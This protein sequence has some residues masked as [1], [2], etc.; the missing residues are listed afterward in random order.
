VTAIASVDKQPGAGDALVLVDVQNDFL[1]GGALGIAAGGAILGPLN[2]YVLEFARGGL[3]V[4]A[5]RDWHPPKHCSFREQGGPWPVHCVAGTWGAELSSRLVLPASVR[6]VSKGQNPMRDAYSGFQGTDLAVQLRDLHC[7]RLFVGGL[8]TDY[9]VR[10]SVKDALAAGFEVV[11]LA[12]AVAA[13]NIHPGDG[14]GALEEMEVSGAE[15][16]SM[17]R[18]VA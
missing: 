2:R 14:A 7:K 11:V 12:D 6:I 9:C 10:A 17:A 1:P 4:F 3:P 18:I 16:V 5:T 15:I 8:A 13:V